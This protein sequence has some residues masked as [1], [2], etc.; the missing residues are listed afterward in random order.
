MSEP[1]KPTSENPQSL[2]QTFQPQSELTAPETVKDEPSF[3]VNDL[4]EALK[5]DGPGDDAPADQIAATIRHWHGI[6]VFVGRKKTDLAWRIGRALA[7]AQSKVPNGSWYNFLDRELSGLS[8]TT[9]WRYVQLYTRSPNGPSSMP[10]TDAYVYLGIANN[11]NNTVEDYLYQLRQLVSKIW[12]L[13]RT[14]RGFSAN[15]LFVET[16][17][18]TAR[19]TACHS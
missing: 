8:K 5:D 17:T 3:T 14:A 15:A 11:G 7:L 6:L 1:S 19:A 18:F 12:K 4:D 9:I 16:G 13:T 10:L 2:G